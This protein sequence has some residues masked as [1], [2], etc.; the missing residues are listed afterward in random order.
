M[1]FIGYFIIAFGLFLIAAGVGIVKTK[2]SDFG[3]NEG[4]NIMIGVGL[5]LIIL[6]VHVGFWSAHAYIDK[7]RNIL[8]YRSGLFGMGK[9]V[10]YKLSDYDT[11]KIHSAEGGDDT[12]D[13]F[14]ISLSHLTNAAA[15]LPLIKSHKRVDAYEAL[16]KLENFLGLRVV[17]TGI[18]PIAHVV[19]P[20]KKLFHQSPRD[21]LPT[22]TKLTVT[23]MGD[24]LT[25]TYPA[26]SMIGG[27]LLSAC[28][29]FFFVLFVF[30]DI[31]WRNPLYLLGFILVW[32][33]VLQLAYWKQKRS[34]NL[35]TL[36]INSKALTIPH[37]RNLKKNLVIPLGDI[38]TLSLDVN[39][40]IV[41]KSMRHLANKIIVQ[42]TTDR[43]LFG[44]GLSTEDVTH[45]YNLLKSRT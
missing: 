15:S 28:M 40:E 23:D 4:L 25:V 45:L 36:S 30:W 42:T 16:K 2:P 13:E 14:I 44:W 17:D 33:L 20:D 31:F 41:P 19:T 12:A 6:G 3:G 34:P 32:G 8:L 43:Y 9:T 22:D 21:A 27:N 7:A 1:P 11:I 18:G 39:D 5:T 26:P 38:Q 29:P 35:F 24:G 37:P 10:K